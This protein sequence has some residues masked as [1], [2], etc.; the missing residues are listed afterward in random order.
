[1]KDYGELKEK[2]NFSIMI[3]QIKK[4]HSKNHQK[5]ISSSIPLGIDK[6]YKTN[7]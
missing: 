5:N 4:K 1:M 3:E 6:K 7:Y 2:L